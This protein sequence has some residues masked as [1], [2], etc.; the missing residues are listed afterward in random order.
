MMT[1]LV[2]YSLAHTHLTGREASPGS[3]ELYWPQLSSAGEEDFVANTGR[4]ALLWEGPAC[5]APYLAGCGLPERLVTRVCCRGFY[6][7]GAAP[8][9]WFAL[10]VDL[11]CSY[12]V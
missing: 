12:L 5:V 7:E 1:G 8:W 3:M 4:R 11:D 10:R 9:A 6:G 2:L